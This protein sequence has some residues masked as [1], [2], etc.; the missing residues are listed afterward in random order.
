MRNYFVNL[1]DAIRNLGRAIIGLP[2]LFRVQLLTTD[3]FYAGEVNI[4]YQ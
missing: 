1:W 2:P 3:T 4:T